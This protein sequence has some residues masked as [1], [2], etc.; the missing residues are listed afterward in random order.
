MSTAETPKPTRTVYVVRRLDWEYNDE[1]YDH[2]GCATP[3]KAFLRRGLAE[4]ECRDREAAARREEADR[5]SNPFEL[6]DFNDLSA[7][8]SLG[9]AELA[10][11][12]R[13]LGLTPPA[14][15]ECFSYHLWW[16]DNAH[17]LTPAKRRAVWLLCD[18]VRFF[19]VVEAEIDFDPEAS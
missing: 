2:Y 8:T 14:D 7:H 6:G 5:G 12:F 3:L 1:F 19:E 17:R 15:G 13:D 11:R 16:D 10:A 18:R 9:A 4:A